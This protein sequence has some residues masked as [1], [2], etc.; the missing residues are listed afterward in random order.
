MLATL[1]LVAKLGYAHKPGA[2]GPPVASAQT[3]RAGA[4]RGRVHA[5]AIHVYKSGS[6]MDFVIEMLTQRVTYARFRHV[7]YSEPF[8]VHLAPEIQL[9]ERTL[10]ERVMLPDG[11]ERIRV[12]IA[13]RVE[14]PSMIAKLAEGYAVG[15]EETTLFDP[16]AR[17]ADVRIQTPAGN[18][19]QIAAQT[20]FSESAAGVHT[21]I[22]LSVRAKIFGVGSMAE[23]FVAAETRKRYE[24]VERVLQRYIDENR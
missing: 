13:P 24:H 7:Y 16:E 5:H 22:E 10:R 6:C 4:M 12:Y 15:Y 20:L 2:A 17:L 19:L 9:K 14:L 1:G 23:R 3:H 8:H 18:L 21:R 11:K